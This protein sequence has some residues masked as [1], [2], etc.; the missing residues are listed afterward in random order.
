MM[1]MLSALVFLT[2]CASLREG[3]R[4]GPFEGMAWAVDCATTTPASLHER[5]EY[6]NPYYVCSEYDDLDMCPAIWV[7]R[8][9]YE[10]AKKEWRDK[11]E[12]AA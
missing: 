6:E 11:C 12:R 3:E 4:V 9:R 2:S 5:Y 8:Y 1:K 7:H 10:W